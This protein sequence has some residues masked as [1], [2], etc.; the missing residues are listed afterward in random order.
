MPGG[1]SRD[2]PT[3][4]D[5]DLIT[6]NLHDCYWIA[7]R[8]DMNSSDHSYLCISEQQLGSM[9]R[10]VVDDTKGIPGYFAIGIEVAGR[11]P[12]ELAPDLRIWRRYLQ[13][14]GKGVRVGD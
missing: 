14:H 1:W 2:L 9:L 10:R 6:T 3:H 5:T 4:A 13:P 11:T 12:V 8:F 7:A